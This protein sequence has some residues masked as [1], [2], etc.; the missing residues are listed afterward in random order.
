[1]RVAGDAEAGTAGIAGRADA[2]ATG[3]AAPGKARAVTAGA[4]AGTADAS[5]GGD[6]R[7]TGE[8]G[9]PDMNSVLATAGFGAAG[10]DGLET[11]AGVA[12]GSQAGGVVGLPALTD[13]GA[14]GAAGLA[15]G[16]A[17]IATGL[18]RE[19]RAGIGAETDAVPP[20]SGEA[21]LLRTA[22]KDFAGASTP[23]AGL[24]KCDGIGKGGGAS[25]PYMVLLALAAG[26]P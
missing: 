17:R 21:L 14:A 2:R 18:L 20:A 8:G 15:P 11:D 3:A 16:A 9:G 25:M 6:G 24:P 23:S 26:L 1:M 7:E 10:D 12:R 13:A 22:S 5:D 4:A 19:R